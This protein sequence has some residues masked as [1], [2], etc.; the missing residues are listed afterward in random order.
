MNYIRTI[1]ATSKLFPPKK[2]MKRKPPMIL[3][4]FL[5]YQP[6][7]TGEKPNLWGEQS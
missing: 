2:V 1:Q 5:S 3:D 4:R 6:V 7:P